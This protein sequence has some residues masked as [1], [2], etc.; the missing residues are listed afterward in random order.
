MLAQAGKDNRGLAESTGQ[1]TAGFLTVNE[2]DTEI[3][4]S[5]R[6]P[7]CNDFRHTFY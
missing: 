2:L 6:A 1:R 3:S 4:W 5:A 7:A